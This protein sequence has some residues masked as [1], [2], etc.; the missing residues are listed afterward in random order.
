MT[1]YSYNFARVLS[2]INRKS[3]ETLVKKFIPFDLTPSEA[4][5]ILTLRHGDGLYQDELSEWVGVDKALTTRALRSLEAK[6]YIARVK[7]ELDSRKRRV[8][9]TEKAK[10]IAD[11]LYEASIEINKVFLANISEEDAKTAYRVLI[12]ITDNLGALAGRAFAKGEEALAIQGE[13][14]YVVRS[15]YE[16]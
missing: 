16:L 3:R 6:G 12:Q 1:E 9:L 10:N 7:D 4:P 14:G 13:K 11:D 8:Y 5:F 2:L 15:K